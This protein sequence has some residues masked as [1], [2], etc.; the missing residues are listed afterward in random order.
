MTDIFLS[1]S[2]YERQETQALAGRLE[3]LGYSVWWDTSLIAGDDYVDVILQ[4][5]D[6]ARAV[7]VI[8]TPTSVRSRW[9]RS[10]A[11]RAD[12]A[13]KLI[14]LRSRSISAHDIP[15]PYDMLQTIGVDNI[16]AITSALA[17]QGIIP[18]KPEV[19]ASKDLAKVLSEIPEAELSRAIELEYWKAIDKSEDVADFA[20]FKEKFPAGSLSELADRRILQFAQSRWKQLGDMMDPELLRLFLADFPNGDYAT[21]ARTALEQLQRSTE[22]QLTSLWTILQQ[23]YLPKKIAAVNKLPGLYGSMDAPGRQRIKEILENLKRDGEVAVK[24]EADEALSK[25]EWIDTIGTLN[26]YE[27]RSL[28]SREDQQLAHAIAYSWFYLM[29]VMIVVILLVALV[30]SSK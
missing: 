5:L 10:E 13:K 6:E 11:G 16:E 23:G 3:D 28:L 17:R 22:N 12:A 19:K 20:R 2:K 14:P 1:Y 27:R 26:G 4:R 29:G 24:I 15:P 30:A 7:I 8:W 18:G 25:I 21:R 9:V